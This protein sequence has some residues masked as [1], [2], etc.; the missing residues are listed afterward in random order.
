[1]LC[2]SEADDGF[3][4]AA[5]PATKASIYWRARTLVVWRASDLAL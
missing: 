3:L 2:H 1:M 4:D 5:E